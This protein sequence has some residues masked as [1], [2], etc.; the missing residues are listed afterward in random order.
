MLLCVQD[1]GQVPNYLTK[2]QEEVQRAQDE[3]DAYVADNFRRG[4]MKQLS[5]FERD[6]LLDGLKTNWEQVNFTVT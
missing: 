2:R 4:A 6:S 3:Y 5:T 1:Y